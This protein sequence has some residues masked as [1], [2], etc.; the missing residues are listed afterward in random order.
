MPVKVIKANNK[1]TTQTVEKTLRVAAYCRVS[2]DSDEQET[3]YEAQVSHYT[4]YINSHPGWTLAGIYADEGISGTQTKTRPEFNAMIEAC[5]RHEIDLVIT[6]SISRFARNTLDCL[7]YIRKLKS[8]NIPIIFEKESTNTMESSGELMVTI[9]ASIAQQESASISQNVKMGIQFG[10]QEGHG[11]LNYSVFLGYKQGGKPGTYAIIPEEA[12]VVRRIYREYLEGFSP[13]MIAEGLMADEICTPAGGDKWYASTI[14]SILENEKYCGDLL[15]QKYYVED[16]LTHRVAKNTGQ[17][18]Q[19]F[20]EDDHDP[21]I[22]KAVYYQ[23]QGEKNRRAGLRL[24]PSKLRFG[25]RL[26]LNGRLVCGKCGRTLKRYVKPDERLTDWRCRQRAMVKKSDTK[27]GTAP[28]CDCRVVREVDVQRAVVSAFNQLPRE[29]LVVMQE[30]LL[31]GEIGRID[32]LLQTLTNQQEQ[33]EERLDQ[34]AALSP[35]INPT[36]VSGTV[37]DG[38][39]EVDFLKSQIIRIREEKNKLY[40]ERAE[41]ANREVQIRMLLEIAQSLPD[42]HTPSAD[43]NQNHTPSAD[44]N[45]YSGFNHNEYSGFNHNHTPS[46]NHNEYSGLEGAMSEGVASEGVTGEEA[47]SGICR[48]YED[49]FRRTRYTVPEGIIVNGQMVAFDNGVVIRY[50]DK[51]IVEDDGYRVVFKAGVEV[52]EK[53]GDLTMVAY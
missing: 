7:N 1:P 33:M 15:M 40:A 51:I 27:E 43:H 52:K 13:Y 14:S 36:V 30:R 9:L 28:R 22:P 35:E 5:E 50:L 53:N 49:F 23:V 25:K 46:I 10:F 39:T 24:D 41:H 6:K 19:Y 37:M 29:E 2:T 34:L 47:T 20:V 32:D 3:S 11:R 26:A 17:K 31:T 4:S 44:H 48:D 42:S 18:P 21:I 12:E 45:E 38:D 8:Y 16:F